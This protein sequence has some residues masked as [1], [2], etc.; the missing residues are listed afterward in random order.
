MRHLNYTHLLYFW[1]VAR[2][3]SVAKAAEVLHLTPQTISGQ[4]KLLEQSISEPLFI[5]SGR[6]LA[7]TETGYVVKQYADEIFSL[8]EELTHRVKTKQA[9]VPT[10]INVGIVDSTPKLVALR[11][12]EPAF[13]LEDPIKVVCRE[14]R[15]DQL[16]GEL[17]IHNLDLVISD[18]PVPAGARVKAYNH[19]LGTS[20]ISLFANK[21]NAALY[22]ENF[23]MSLQD[24]SMLLPVPESLTRRALDEWFD[25]LGISPM[26][27]AEFEDSALMKAFG[28]A[29]VGIFPA[30]TA[31]A[32][33][34]CAMYNAECIGEANS[35]SETYYAISPERKLKHPAVLKLT[36]QARQQLFV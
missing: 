24:A 10:T 29:G 13:S 25:N 23:P 22:K 17:A 16:L 7:L 6:G 33:E 14:G 31:I 27:V 18:T 3:G 26:V 32:K 9:I 4:I 35:V 1:T 5:K 21:S 20:G 19:P 2:E 28:E 12:L 15:L 36:E 11:V 8:G 34:V 30:P